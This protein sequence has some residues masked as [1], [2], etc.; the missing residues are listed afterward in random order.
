MGHYSLEM[1]PSSGTSRGMNPM[2]MVVM[3]AICISVC[4]THRLAVDCMAD[5]NVV[6]VDFD[7]L[8]TVAECLFG[9]DLFAIDET[10]RHGCACHWASDSSSAHGVENGPTSA[11]RTHHKASSTHSSHSE[12]WI[13]GRATETAASNGGHAAKWRHHERGEWVVHLR[14]MV[15]MRV[16]GVG[17]RHAVQGR[18]VA[19]IVIVAMMWAVMGVM[20]PTPMTT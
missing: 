10:R 2:A 17:G 14:A 6:L 11:H 16:M 18:V 13:E 4:A 12:E 15:D 3:M 5:Q 8:A 7:G 20:R 19:I 9:C 1:S